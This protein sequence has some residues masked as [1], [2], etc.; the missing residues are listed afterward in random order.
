[1]SKGVELEDFMRQ[2]HLI[3]T[4]EDLYELYVLS[5]NQRIERS[6]SKLSAFGQNVTELEPDSY[7]DWLVRVGICPHAI[8]T[9]NSRYHLE[10]V[11]LLDGQMG[12]SMPDQNKSLGETPAIFFQSLNIVRR[13]RSLLR[14][15]KKE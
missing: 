1:M 11:V 10:A 2:K 15:E 4:H 6:I 8:V 9:D 13:E 7:L 12:L 3:K 14:T 5:E